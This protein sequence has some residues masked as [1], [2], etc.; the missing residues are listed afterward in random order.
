MTTQD[1]IRG[2]EDFEKSS[3][4]EDNG[5]DL[6]GAVRSWVHEGE[7]SLREILAPPTMLTRRVTVSRPT[8]QPLSPTLGGSSIQ[9][10]EPWK[11]VKNE[12]SEDESLTHRV[13]MLANL[14][15]YKEPTSLRRGAPNPETKGPRRP[16]QIRLGPL[17]PTLLTPAPQRSQYISR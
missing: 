13:K 7:E 5:S 4:T 3:D 17:S 15:V 9:V 16:P 6:S 14:P 10:I 2:P 1:S 12:A 11:L 8:L